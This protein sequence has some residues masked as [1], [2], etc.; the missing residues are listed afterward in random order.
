MKA[1]KLSRHVT[2]IRLS[3]EN[4]AALAAAAFKTG[5]SVNHCINRFVAIGVAI[6]TG[7]NEGAAEIVASINFDVK[8]QQIDLAA[9]EQKSEIRKSAKAGLTAQP[10][11][12]RRRS[13]MQS[14][15]VA[16][17]A[18]AEKGTVA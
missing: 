13:R 3:P 5:R 8:M 2:T 1:K 4:E 14:E 6:V 9:A 11:W 7:R 16:E 10:P 12:R 17:L 18:A 15:V